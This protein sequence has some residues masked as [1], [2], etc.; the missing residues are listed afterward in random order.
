MECNTC[1]GTGKVDEI[2][3]TRIAFTLDESGIRDWNVLLREWTDGVFTVS[4]EA[5]AGSPYMK[6]TDYYEFEFN[7]AP[8]AEDILI[9]LQEKYEEIADLQLN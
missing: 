7:S 5:D 4:M 3:A 2:E 6:V 9:A 1:K 8:S